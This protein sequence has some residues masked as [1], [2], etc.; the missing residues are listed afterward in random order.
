MGLTRIKP[1]SL[2]VG[3]LCA[4]LVIWVDR[5]T[6]G[7]LAASLG[8]EATLAEPIGGYLGRLEVS[9]THGPSGTSVTVTAENLLPNQE[10][11]LVWRTVRGQWNVGN[12]EYRWLDLFGDNE[13]FGDV[14]NP[15]GRSAW[16]SYS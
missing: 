2:C 16:C 8:P 11:Q 14:Y 5:A 9:P 15:S 4:L 13:W 12:A 6:A 10:F 7:P 1:L 3:A